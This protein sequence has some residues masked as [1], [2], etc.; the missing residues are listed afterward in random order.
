ML[1]ISIY[2]KKLADIKI[3]EFSYLLNP[4]DPFFRKNQV[5]GFGIEKNGRLISHAA[6]IFDKRLPKNTANFGFFESIDSYDVVKVLF[7]E[8]DKWCKEKGV[9]ILRGPINL[10]TWHGYR[11]LA[12]SETDPFFLEPINKSYYPNHFKKLGFLPVAKALSTIDEISEDLIKKFTREVYPKA[13][14]KIRQFN[15]DRAEN[16]LNILYKMAKQIFTYTWNYVEINFDEFF[17]LY[18]PIIPLVDPEFFVFAQEEDGKDIGFIFSI[19]D[20]LSKERIIIK[21]AAVLPEYRKQK[22]ASFLFNHVLLKAKQKGYKKVV[23]ALM[24]EDNQ[25][26][27]FVQSKDSQ[28]HYYQAFEKKL[29]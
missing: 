10:T 16:D 23:F 26:I 24:N 21:T 27:K 13:L 12:S 7:G 3:R 1:V 22:V 18:K 8:I 17:Y 20:Y 6:V 25:A 29:S 15:I 5:F 11:F 19:N 2:P 9:K 28:K 14:L 4:V